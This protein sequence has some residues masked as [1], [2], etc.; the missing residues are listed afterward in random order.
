MESEIFRIFINIF[1]NYLEGSGG[2][3]SLLPAIK[4]SKYLDF[5]ALWREWR[6]ILIHI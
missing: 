2:E 6:E 5:K 3:A 4:R 1:W